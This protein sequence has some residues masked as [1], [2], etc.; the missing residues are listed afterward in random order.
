ML[1]VFTLKQQLNASQQELAQSLYQQDAACRVIARL[2]KE[3]AEMKKDIS[4]RGHSDG[5]SNGMDIDTATDS[6]AVA[7]TADLLARIQAKTNELSEMRSKRRIPASTASRDTVAS[8][9]ETSHLAP[10]K[11]GPSNAVSSYGSLVVSA[12]NDKTVSVLDGVTATKLASLTGPTKAQ[13]SV[14]IGSGP[15]GGDSARIVSSDENGLLH[16]WDAPTRADSFTLTKKIEVANLTSGVKQVDLHPVGDCVVLVTDNLFAL[17][18][19]SADV[20]SVHNIIKNNGNATKIAIHPDGQI[21]AVGTT[22]GAIAIYSAVN[23]SLLATFEG[24]TAAITSLSFSENGYNL[25]STGLD[26]MARVWDLESS[27]CTSS[28]TLSA[29]PSASSYDVSGRFIAITVTP[30]SGPRELRVFMSKTG[31]LVSSFPLSAK[32]DNKASPPNSIVFGPDASFIAI[33]QDKNV[34]FWSS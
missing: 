15:T 8:Y 14:K 24:H 1:E 26:E 6:G 2:M 16:I 30:A 27:A 9:K 34:R 3:N 23:A 10:H 29:S 17:V 33:S 28:I 25:T 19:A 21:M 4:V 11:T 7:L 12:G 13:V 32:T 18:D 31:D 22:G 20:S 5:S